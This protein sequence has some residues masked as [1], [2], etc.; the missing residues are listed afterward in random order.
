MKSFLSI[1][2]ASL[3]RVGGYLASRNMFPNVTAISFSLSLL[4]QAQKS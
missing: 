4:S 1:D 3:V 2:Q